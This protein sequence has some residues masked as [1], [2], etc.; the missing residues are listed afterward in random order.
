MQGTFTL[1]FQAY[2]PSTEEGK[3]KAQLTVQL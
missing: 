2:I 3:S 1:N